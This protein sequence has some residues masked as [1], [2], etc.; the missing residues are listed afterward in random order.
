MAEPKLTKSPKAYL[1]D[2]GEN[3]GALSMIRVA[4]HP[5]E[6]KLLG[7][8]LD[9]RLGFWNLE[10]PAEKL[11]RGEYVPGK[12]VC[13]HELGWIRGF[14]V[15]PRGEF[16]AT[17]GSDRRLRIWKWEGGEPSSQP[18]HDL[19]A[20][21][22]WVEAVGYSPDGSR[23]A[24]LG[25]D[26]RL[27]LWDASGL[28]L[29]RE[30]PAHEGIPRD[31]AWSRD[32]KV[33][34]TGG[35]DGYVI[36][37]DPERLEPRRKIF[38]AETSEQQGQNPAIGG[39]HRLAVSR[40]GRFVFAAADRQLA[41]AEIVTGAGFG[42]LKEIGLDVACSPSADFI[43]AGQNVVRFY[44]Y[45]VAAFKPVPSEPA[46]DAKGRKT[47]AKLPPLPGKQL[48]ESKRDDFALGIA[49]TNDGQSLALGKP[50]GTIEIWNVG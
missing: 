40:D 5:T 38:L 23:L 50:N 26:R 18:L 34:V 19:A 46:V 8:C 24:T 42:F 28:R 16:V 30:A 27:K 48:S 49:F 3:R 20:H 45:D 25:A 47:L 15:H 2:D 11:K 17:G 6:R 36:V 4:F 7:Q 37:W 41:A 1:V 31:L 43:A 22:S 39:V 29:I 32:G 9:R 10:A 44:S 33:L 14:D 12:L 35:E 21:E 13:P